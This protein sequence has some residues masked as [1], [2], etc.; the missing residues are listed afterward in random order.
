MEFLVF[1]EDSGF[2]IVD[3]DDIQSAEMMAGQV[4]VCLGTIDKIDHI[5][6][7]RIKSI[8]KMKV[9]KCQDCGER[10]GCIRFCHY[11]G[12]E[13]DSYPEDLF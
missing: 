6:L 3:A 12:A 9:H 1:S 4:S 13:Q 2:S 11:C 10:I 7:E 5:I 8:K